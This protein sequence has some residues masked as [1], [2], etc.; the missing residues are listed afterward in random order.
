MNNT[1]LFR[2]AIRRR[3]SAAFPITPDLAIIRRLKDRI[4]FTAIFQIRQ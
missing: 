4:R 2:S 1:L 3:P